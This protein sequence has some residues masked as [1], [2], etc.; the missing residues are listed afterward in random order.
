MYLF[1]KSLKEEEGITNEQKD[2]LWDFHLLH[3]KI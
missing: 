2:L 3:E 1:R